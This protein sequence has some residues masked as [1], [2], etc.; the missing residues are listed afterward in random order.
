[1][2][3]PVRVGVIGCGEITQLMHLRFIDELPE[4][5]LAALCDLS[6]AVLE[7][8]GAKYQVDRLYTSYEQ[9]LADAD[10]DA[11][12]VATPD[13][14]G[15]AVAALD[16]GKHLLLEKPAA[17]S[18]ADARAIAEAAGRASSTAMMAYMRVYDPG[19]ELVRAQTQDMDSIRLVR[20]HNF[21]G[22]YERHGSL[23]PVLRPQAEEN[24]GDQFAETISAGTTRVLEQA[25]GP[26]RAAQHLYWALLMGSTHDLS[27]IRDLI[28]P[29]Q[30]VLYAHVDG[31]RML[32]CV[33]FARAVCTLEWESGGGYDWWDQEITV[34]GPDRSAVARFPDPYIPYVP[35]AAT[36][37]SLEQDS[38]AVRSLD[39]SSE[40]AFRREWRHFAECIQSGQ[41]PRTTIAGGVQDVELIAEL[42]TRGVPR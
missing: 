24:I 38:S 40:P 27:I 11:V 39:V 3:D 36:V 9:L 22:N 41:E 37:H 7:R 29:P 15:P 25:V 17:Y 2:T 31:S 6:G 23:F 10:V 18:V 42:V 12:L 34:Y 5:T 28:G 4:L 20:S 8:L 33:S 30:D 21:G 14:V 16:R 26:D 35:T 32:A 1:V 19:H 13:H